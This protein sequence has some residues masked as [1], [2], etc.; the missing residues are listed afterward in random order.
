MTF[1]EAEERAGKLW[2]N[3]ERVERLRY[4]PERW[5][6]FASD[7]DGRVARPHFMDAEGHPTCHPDCIAR[8]AA[9]GVLPA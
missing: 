4:D 6:V 8:E 9:L 1:A 5:I 3:V 2:T 7:R